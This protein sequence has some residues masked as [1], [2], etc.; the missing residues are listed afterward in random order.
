MTKKLHYQYVLLQGS[1]YAVAACFYRLYGAS[2]T[3][4]RV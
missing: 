4:A 2:F 3:K 1:Y